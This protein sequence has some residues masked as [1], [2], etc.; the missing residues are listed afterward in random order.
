MHFTGRRED[1]VVNQIEG[2][3][4]G[5][6]CKD[7]SSRV[8]SC[9]QVHNICPQGEVQTHPTL[10][11]NELVN[12]RQIVGGKVHRLYKKAW[13]HYRHIL[14]GTQLCYT[15]G[16]STS[17]VWCMHF[18][19][20]GVPWVLQSSWKWYWLQRSGRQKE[21]YVEFFGFLTSLEDV[22]DDRLDKEL[23]THTYIYLLEF[24][25]LSLCT[26]Q[27]STVNCKAKFWKLIL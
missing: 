15:K 9:N 3:Q 24:M 2:S 6:F 20:H 18:L 7:F 21:I 27:T 11:P 10:T 1:Q 17:D 5:I 26:K 14:K 16:N 22:A 23:S 19:R 12:L 8:S 4:S 13:T 25:N